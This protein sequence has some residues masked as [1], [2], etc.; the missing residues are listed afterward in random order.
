[1]TYMWNPKEKSYNEL[2]FQ[3]RKRFLDIENKFMFMKGER[4][5]GRNKLGGYD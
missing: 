1:M 2:I 5:W 4:L 3:N